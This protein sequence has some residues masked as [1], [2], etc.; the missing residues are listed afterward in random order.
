MWFYPQ[1]PDA[2]FMATHQ[3]KDYL[4]P[5]QMLEHYAQANTQLVVFQAGSGTPPQYVP[6]GREEMKGRYCKG[7]LKCP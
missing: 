4:P 3:L 2:S 6:V 1:P 5:S 7:L